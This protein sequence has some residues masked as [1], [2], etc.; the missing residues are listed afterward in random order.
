MGIHILVQIWRHMP[1]FQ[2]QSGEPANN[3]K[4]A[5]NFWSG[6]KKKSIKLMSVGVFKSFFLDRCTGY[7]SECKNDEEKW[8]G[9]VMLFIAMGC[10]LQYLVPTSYQKLAIF[11]TWL[12]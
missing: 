5:E 12:P 1:N 10:H 3:P 4:T 11:S 8:Q 9:N 2:D 6:M 7:D